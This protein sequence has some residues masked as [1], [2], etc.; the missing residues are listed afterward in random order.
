[1][2]D[3]PSYDYIEA[4]LDKLSEQ[5]PKEVEQLREYIRDLQDRIVTYEHIVASS[6]GWILN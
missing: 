1:M 6:Q 2:N 4:I 5:Y 3:I